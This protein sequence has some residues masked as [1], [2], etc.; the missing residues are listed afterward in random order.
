[1][2]GIS[3][4]MSDKLISR[5]VCRRRRRESD[6]DCE[7]TSSCHKVM[8]LPVGQKR[9][10]WW[11]RQKIERLIRF[12]S[13]FRMSED[14]GKTKERDTIGKRRVSDGIWS[15]DEQLAEDRGEVSSKSLWDKNQWKKDP[16]DAWEE[17]TNN[18]WAIEH[19]NNSSVGLVDE[20]QRS[21][22]ENFKREEE[23]ELTVTL[24]NNSHFNN[25]QW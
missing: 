11:K 3:W 9:C 23:K 2:F 18:R 7:I 16:V 5:W 14:D 20:N 15:W 24:S 8:L 13:D 1:M 21:Y 22:W 12:S 6:Y 19:R 10:W 25:R 17:K 4:C